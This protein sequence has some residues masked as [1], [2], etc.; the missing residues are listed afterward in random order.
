MANDRS[1]QLGMF[2]IINLAEHMI[3]KLAIDIGAAVL[4]EVCLGPFSVGV[5]DCGREFWEVEVKEVRT[6]AHNWAI[7]LVELLDS[8]RVVGRDGLTKAPEVRPS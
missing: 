2:D 5:V 1:L 4:V 3:R 8:W 6:Q 7:F